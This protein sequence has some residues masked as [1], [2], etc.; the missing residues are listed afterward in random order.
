MPENPYRTIVEQATDGIFLSDAQG[1]YLEVNSAASQL[2]GGEPHE[3]LGRQIGDLFAPVTLTDATVRLDTIPAGTTV[4]AEWHLRRKD[5]V[6]VPVEITAKRLP[7]GRILAM[8]RD[9]TA[10]VQAVTALAASEARFRALVEHSTD[11]I[12]LIDAAGII[13]YASPAATRLLGYADAAVGGH[14]VLEFVHPQDQPTARAV[15][16]SLAAQAGASITSEVR[17]RHQDGSWRWLE[18]TTTNLL[19]QPGLAAYVVNFRDITVRRA[20]LAETVRLAAIVASAKDTA[21]L[22]AIVAASED[23]IIGLS[24]DG[25]IASWNAGA[26][27]LYGYP[28]AD[29][30]GQP[31]TLLTP[32]DRAGEE[33]MV[34]TA[35][36][37]GTAISRLETV[38]Q[39]RDGTQLEVLLSVAPLRDAEGR[40]TGAATIA[41]DITDH[42]HFEQQLIQQA[43]YDQLTGLP[44]RALFLD[45]LHHALTRTPR[46][47]ERVVVLFLDLDRFK[48]VND[49]LGHAAGDTLLVAVGKRLQTCLRPGDTLARF[50]GD[51][52][53]VL[54]EELRQ[55]AEA[56]RIA[57]RLLKAL[58]RPFALAGQDVLVT[59]SIGIAVRHPQMTL[60]VEE[61][62]RQ[63]D[64]ALYRSKATGTGQ[65]VFYGPQLES[66][67]A[68][69]SEVETDLRQALSQEAFRL[70]YQPVVELATGTVVGVEAL[71]RW[72]RPGKA[73][74]GP[75]VF[76]PVAEDTGQIVAIG[77][78]VL[79]EACRQALQWQQEQPGE[80]LQ[81][82]VNIS[83]REFQE[84]DLVAHIA[85]TLTTTGFPPEQLCLE[86]T[87]T[88]VMQDVERAIIT[89]TALKGLGLRLSL[90]DFGTGYSSLGYLR[91]FPIDLLKLDRSFI[92]ELTEDRGAEAI[93]RAIITLGHTMGLAVTAEGI[94]TAAQ[95]ARV[96][97]LGCEQGQG[98][99]FA[100]AVPAA[101]VPALRQPGHF[102]VRIPPG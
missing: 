80:A 15:G 62:L 26:E 60:T 66:A 7:D 83:A 87:E 81:L 8:V 99:Y 35:I 6:V 45:R 92:T 47:P 71:L 13:T 68:Q 85:H 14:H 91:R 84:P 90:D 43:F 16:V 50:G 11:G 37:T 30:I 76:I 39:H 32:P 58:Q 78:W 69:R 18:T 1:V 54:L 53:T 55:P 3:L 4:R 33:A 20:A 72:Q 88:A 100:P 17:V 61:L 51:E 52:F 57:A 95:L 82:F 2:F 56:A 10:R 67:A 46:Q 59:A 24:L 97:A 5:G 101:A 74:L 28:A 65:V 42:K 40:V 79:A 86:L 22:A 75:A 89:L 29:V 63:A 93:V 12:V 9:I 36:A 77:R 27:Q 34:L 94:E 70:H 23:A 102:R 31:A 49:T 21:R 73:A 64:S 48:Q 98:F 44:N 41:R 38:Q 19:A 25:T 96:Q